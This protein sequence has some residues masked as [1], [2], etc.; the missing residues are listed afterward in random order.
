MFYRTASLE[1]Y[2]KFLNLYEDGFIHLITKY[3]YFPNI[4]TNTVIYIPPEGDFPEDLD[5]FKE[6]KD[7][8]SV[9]VLY[10]KELPIIKSSKSKSAHKEL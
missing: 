4:K 6:N 10:H 3:I 1:S 2:R 5:I 7:Y 9:R 8:I